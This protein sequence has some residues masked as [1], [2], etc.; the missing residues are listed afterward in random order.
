MQMY[1]FTCTVVYD[2][3]SHHLFSYI[4]GAQEF[5][6]VFWTLSR[7]ILYKMT[8]DDASLLM[9]SAIP[10]LSVIL[11]RKEIGI[12]FLCGSQL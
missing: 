1:W 5:L 6:F 12:A 3:F 2:S 9:I 10:Y 4:G 11:T 8:Q 7:Q